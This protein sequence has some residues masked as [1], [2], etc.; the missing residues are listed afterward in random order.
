MR[1]TFDFYLDRT[2]KR[3]RPEDGVVAK[4]NEPSL[5]VGLEA[6]LDSMARVV[7]ETGCRHT[8]EGLE[9]K[10]AVLKKRLKMED[11]RREGLLK[12]SDH[13]HC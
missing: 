1:T 6:L 13:S 12:A 11:E 9:A 2:R 5:N 3:Q 7:N 10:M 4:L 8:T